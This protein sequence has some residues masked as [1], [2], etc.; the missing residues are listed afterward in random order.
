MDSGKLEQNHQGFF[1]AA[2]PEI[3]NHCRKILGQ[4]IA[5]RSFLPWKSHVASLLHTS[6]FL[7]G[8]SWSCSS[9]SSSG[10]SAWRTDQCRAST[11]THQQQDL[12]NKAQKRQ[13]SIT[14]KTL[15]L[16]LW[17][18][19]PTGSPWRRQVRCKDGK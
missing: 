19:L 7:W 8:I 4:K 13:T 10:G 1:G 12:I 14:K 9:G 11:P 6:V 15:A 3:T 5:N 2:Q 18:V 17:I 16:G